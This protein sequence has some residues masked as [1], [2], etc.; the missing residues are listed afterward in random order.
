MWTQV[1]KPRS[2]RGPGAALG[3]VPQVGEGTGMSERLPRPR[4]L[5]R[6]TK[7]EGVSCQGPQGHGASLPRCPTPCPLQLKP[8]AAQALPQTAPQVAVRVSAAL[9]ATVSPQ[10]LLLALLPQNTVPPHSSPT[11]AGSSGSL[12]PCRVQAAPQSPSAAL[13]VSFSLKGSFAPPV[14]L[15]SSVGPG[16]D[17]AAGTAKGYPI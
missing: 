10:S 3:P 14:P 7:K 15:G 8:L 6:Q 11:P 5:D 4:A 9:L 2:G 12:Q 16:R 1:I 17:P 13:R